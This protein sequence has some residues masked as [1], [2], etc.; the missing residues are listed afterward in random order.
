M[1]LLPTEILGLVNPKGFNQDNY[2]ND[3]LH[4]LHNDYPLAGQKIGTKNNAAGISIAIIEDD[5]FSV[6]KNK[7]FIPLKK[8]I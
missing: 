2:C 6:G 5:K 1:Q 4:D 3:E 8:K 7:N